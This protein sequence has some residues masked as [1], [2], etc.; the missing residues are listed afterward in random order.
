M[1]KNV[2]A[3]K[4]ARPSQQRAKP[5]SERQLGSSASFVSCVISGQ[6]NEV[7]YPRLGFLISKMGII[8]DTRIVVRIQ[9]DNESEMLSTVL[10]RQCVFINVS[11]SNNNKHYYYY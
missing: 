6:E 10:G 3:V 8:V 2:K 5:D 1:T 9:G 4:R 11:C 7:T